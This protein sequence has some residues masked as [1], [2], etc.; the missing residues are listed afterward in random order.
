M[1]GYRVV[2]V[3][4]VV[5]RIDIFVTATGNKK[6]ITR[7]HMDKMKVFKQ[8]IWTKALFD[9][10]KTHIMRKLLQNG[11]VLCNMGHSNTE[12]DVQSLKTHDLTWEKVGM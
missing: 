2:R 3:K 11:A 4:D 7:C 12:I 6:I 1:D 8:L 9:S 5:E 10:S